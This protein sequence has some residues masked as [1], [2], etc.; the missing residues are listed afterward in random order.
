[1][2]SFEGDVQ[3][4]FMQS[5][6]IS[7]RDVFGSNISHDLRDNGSA[8]AVTAANRQVCTSVDFGVVVNVEILPGAKQTKFFVVE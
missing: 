5:F 4:T 1:M 2:L 3:D 7:Y 6:Q 8:I